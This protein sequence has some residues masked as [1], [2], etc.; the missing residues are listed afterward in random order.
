M[1]KVLLI[2][3]LLLTSITMYNCET[4]DTDD[5]ILKFAEDKDEIEEPEDRNN[6]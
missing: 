3:G 2:F 6:G 5:E 4:P 1:K